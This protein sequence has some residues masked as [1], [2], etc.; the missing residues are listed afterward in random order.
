[1]AGIDYDQPQL[2]IF[3]HGATWIENIKFLSN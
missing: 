3:S 1:M 2:S